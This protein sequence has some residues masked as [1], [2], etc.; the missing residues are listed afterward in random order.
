M[1]GPGAVVVCTALDSRPHML[2]LDRESQTLRTALLADL[3]SETVQR[4][5][6]GEPAT[7]VQ[8]VQR[9]DDIDSYRVPTDDVAPA[10]AFGGA[11]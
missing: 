9:A 1:T 11:R 6:Y 4:L 7:V 2:V 3:A 5:R 8:A 10:P